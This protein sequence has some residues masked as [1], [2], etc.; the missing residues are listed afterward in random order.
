MLLA[1]AA[2]L[3]LAACG[4]EPERVPVV[5]EEVFDDPFRRLPPQQTPVVVRA[6]AYL[7]R[8]LETVRVT[9]LDQ[10]RERLGE[11]AVRFDG[12]SEQASPATDLW[13]RAERETALLTGGALQPER[14]RLQRD[15]GFGPD[16][17]LWE[18]TGT[19]A[20]GEVADAWVVAFHRGVDPGALQ[21]AADD[22]VGVLAGGQVLAGRRVVVAGSA[23][24][25][26]ED[27]WRRTRTVVDAGRQGD[28][29][30]VYL[31]AA[32]VPMDDLLGEGSQEADRLRAR[33][34]LDALDPVEAFA[35]VFADEVATARLGM[36]DFGEPRGDLFAR[37]DLADDWPDDSRFARA[38][39]RDPVVDPSSGRIGFPMRDPARAAA[40][41]DAGATPYAVCA[42]SE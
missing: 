28:V 22:G 26:A 40:T 35:V 42:E 25:G 9:D 41:T 3:G 27:S 12:P 33:H 31:R 4:D 38:F 30:S 11:S 15:Y 10:V 20:D 24:P 2:P 39:A 32:C 17:V 34:D 36:A 6:S 1:L 23:E 21:R 14:D 8:S 29:E 18:A 16:D 19:D 7:P 5:T 13:R 37:A